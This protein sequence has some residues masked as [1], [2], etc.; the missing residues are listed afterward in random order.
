MNVSAW[1]GESVSYS[2]T[3]NIQTYTV[4]GLNPDPYIV[5][6]GVTYWQAGII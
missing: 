2:D 3:N 1:N 6:S 4:P 5:I